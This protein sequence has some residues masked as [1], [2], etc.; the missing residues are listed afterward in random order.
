METLGKNAQ[1]RAL[2]KKLFEEWENRP[3]SE[4]SFQISTVWD[5]KNNKYLL[6]MVGWDGYKRVHNVLLHIE[7][8]KG[9]F[10]IEADQTPH[11]FACDLVD[12]GVPKDR[13]VLAFKHPELRSYSDY[14]EAA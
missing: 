14:A 5:E 7:L 10:C 2:L 12:N 11:G 3:H 4:S 1:D 6:L 9:K 13:I 8:R